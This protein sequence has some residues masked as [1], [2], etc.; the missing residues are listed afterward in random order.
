MHTHE[1]IVLGLGGM[2]SAAL[3]HLA[4][5]GARVL[6]IEQFAI[7]H[8][9]GS[10]HGG[11][12][13]CRKAYFEHPDY[14]P[15]LHRAYQLWDELEHMAECEL[16]RRAGLLLAGPPDG[17]II[18]GVRRSADEHGLDIQEIGPADLA[19]RFQ[20]LAVDPG[21]CAL[22]EP[23][24]GYLRVEDCVRAQ[25]AQAL[26][27]G[28]RIMS[29]TTV[30]HW[31]ADNKGV[32]VNTSDGRYAAAALVICGGAWSSGLLAELS[33]PLEIRR[34]VVVWLGDFDDECR[35]ERG[36]PVFAF[37]SGGGFYYGFPV[38][39]EQGMKIAQHF[40]GETVLDP[41][42]PDR[43]L[44]PE[45]EQPLRGFVARHLPRARPAIGRHS[46]CMYTMTPDEH[47]IIDRHRDHSNVVFAAGFSGHGFKFSPV[48]GSILADL[49]LDRR[50]QEPIAFL[51][52]S[53]PALKAR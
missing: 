22:F 9:R 40:G 23:N 6:G 42:K 7:A 35:V 38:I 4:R 32:V 53:R 10:S 49:A 27:S 18:P 28:A 12:R 50:T 48:V 19:E 21:M 29:G 44:R 41:N 36:C 13:I 20:A 51:R 33:L 2:G 8:D 30:R 16:F 45:D 26:R 25:L 24:A 31:S 14:V 39:D 15:L 43:V 5:R 46:V 47:F 11:T 34:K 52:A 17:Q 37:E 3:H 1:V